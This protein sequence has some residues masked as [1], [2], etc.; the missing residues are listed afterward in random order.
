[1]IAFAFLD[2]GKWMAASNQK[3]RLGRRFV[4]YSMA[5][6]VCQRHGGDRGKG[7]D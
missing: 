7:N 2:T 4:R 6:H 1:M 5:P 3:A